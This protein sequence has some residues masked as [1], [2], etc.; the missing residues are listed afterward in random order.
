MQ[1]WLNGPVLFCEWKEREEEYSTYKRMWNVNVRVWEWFHLRI[2]CA[3]VFTLNVLAWQ[4]IHLW[5]STNNCLK[6]SFV[7]VVHIN[8][9][10]SQNSFDWLEAFSQFTPTCTHYPLVKSQ[11]NPQEFAMRKDAE[12]EAEAETALFEP[13]TRKLAIRWNAAC[14]HVGLGPCVN[15]GF[16]TVMWWHQSTWLW[17]KMALEWV[18]CWDVDESVSL[19]AW[20]LISYASR[21]PFV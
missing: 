21:H 7:N 16:L 14:V 5:K 12:K 18:F 19:E 4:E 10:R 1:Y 17:I 2:L 11:L 8:T 3:R 20:V 15:E 6:T 9:F 13:L